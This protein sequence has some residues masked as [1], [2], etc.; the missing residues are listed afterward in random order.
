MDCTHCKKGPLKDNQTYHNDN[1]QSFCTECYHEVCEGLKQG[2]FD[3]EEYDEYSQMLLDLRIAFTQLM[4]SAKR[5]C[6][7]KGLLKAK[8][9]NPFLKHLVIS[10]EAYSLKELKK[11]RLTLSM[12]ESTL[13]MRDT[14]ASIDSSN[15]SI[16]HHKFGLEFENYYSKGLKIKHLLKLKVR[17]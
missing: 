16:H 10:E 12:G 15:T 2:V 14:L 1:K 5:H 13:I 6:L 17:S 11:V 4:L 7:D 9:Y 8:D 3:D